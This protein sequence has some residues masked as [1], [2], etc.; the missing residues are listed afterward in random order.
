MFYGTVVAWWKGYF[1]KAWDWS[2]VK[3]GLR[4]PPPPP[5]GLTLLER[6]KT[7]SKTTKGKVCIGAAA[8]AGAYG[9]YEGI[10][11]YQGSGESDLLE[12]PTGRKSKSIKLRPRKY[13]SKSTWNYWIW[14]IVVV[15]L[16]GVSMG[17]YFWWDS[18]STGDEVYDFEP[19][20]E[21]GLNGM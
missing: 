5:A 3:V 14:I 13:R 12:T 10:Q 7:F 8:V 9:I 15:V 6:A 1:R 18:E 11:W 2:L 16:L 20:I 4:Q 17:M 19:D 21:N